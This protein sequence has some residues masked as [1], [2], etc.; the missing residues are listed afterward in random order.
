[1]AL[2]LRWALAIESC[3]IMSRN[4]EIGRRADRYNSPSGK[5]LPPEKRNLKTLSSVKFALFLLWGMEQ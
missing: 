1:M 4:E 3:F 5:C 2:G